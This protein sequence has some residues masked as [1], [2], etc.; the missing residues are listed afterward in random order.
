MK[1]LFLISYYTMNEHSVNVK[2]KHP[3]GINL[4]SKS[5]NTKKGGA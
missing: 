4:L 1:I 5:H 3:F 2:I